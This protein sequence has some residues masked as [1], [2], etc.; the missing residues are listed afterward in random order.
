[1]KKQELEQLLKTLCADELVEL[2]SILEKNLN[3]II[4]AKD[5][6]H[7]IIK[8]ERKVNCCPLCGSIHIVKN[9]VRKD[10]NRQKYLC[11]DCKKSFSDTTNTITFHSRKSYSIWENY[12]SCLLKGMTLTDT[13]KE[14]GISVT[15]SFTWRH[16]I[17]KTLS[18]FNNDIKLS[19]TIELD[20]IYFSINLKGTKM[21]KMPR[22]S[23]KRTSSAFRGISHH[24]VCVTTA[25]DS[26]DNMFFQISGLGV[27]TTEM[28]VKLKDRFEYGSI[29]VTDSKRTFDKF[30]SETN[31][32]HNFIPS[33]F[34]KSDS[35]HT[36]ATLNGLHS[37]LK[38][39][40]RKFR[41]VS[42]KH[43]QGYLDLFRYLKHI[44]YKIEYEKRINET[45]CFSIPS[46]TTVLID[47]IYNKPMPI[48]L[49]V[50]YEEYKYGIFA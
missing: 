6:N 11:R 47:N 45:Y 9:G 18:K 42:T 35:G 12:I 38:T 4:S 29:L 16:K 32:K 23:K 20:A 17:L 43:L 2:K 31:M 46:Y 14:I 36:L 7:K 25:T 13:A 30:A 22:Y 21:D 1:M 49:K 39:W 8:R 28:L 48:D 27:E 40:L 24:K 3:N 26:R 19:E 10:T 44:K 33:K 15:T 34:Y 41:G 5:S 50:A 37:E